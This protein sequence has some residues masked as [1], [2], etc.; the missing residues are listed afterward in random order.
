MN[1]MIEMLR[2]LPLNTEIQVAYGSVLGQT[3]VSTGTI[4]AKDDF[5]M[6]IMGQN[7]LPSLISY[8]TVDAFSI[9]GSPAAQ[10]KA[11]A[12]EEKAVPEAPAKVAPP[13]KKDLLC[14]KNIDV[15]PF[16]VS[17][18]ALK[19][20]FDV[21]CR[22][23][24]KLLQAA[25]DSFF[26]GVRNNNVDKRIQAAQN[27]LRTFQQQEDLGFA[28]SENACRLVAQLLSRTGRW[29]AELYAQGQMWEEAALSSFRSKD[30]TG[31]AVNAALALENPRIPNRREDMII[32][33]AHACAELDDAS[34]LEYLKKGEI[35]LPELVDDLILNKQGTPVKD[36]EA[37]WAL[38]QSLYPQRVIAGLLE[39]PATSQVL[40][41]SIS[42]VL[43]VNGTGTI[44]YLSDGEEL[45]VPF[46]NSQ[47]EDAVVM[48]KIT[49]P[50]AALSERGYMVRF[51]LE[52]GEAAHIC[53]AS[54]PLN[55]AHEA[56]GNDEYR[57]ACWICRNGLK[58]SND[59]ELW[60]LMVSAAADS[61]DT[62]LMQR[63]ADFCDENRARFPQ[64]CKGLSHFGQLHHALHNLEES[65]RLTE[66]AL[67][68]TDAPAKLRSGVLVQYMKYAMRLYNE[69]A[70]EKWLR[71][72]HDKA[73]EWLRI[74]SEE[75][76]H[77]PNCIKRHGQVLIWKIRSL[78]SLGHLDKAEEAYSQLARNYPN[79]PRL[80][81]TSELI[82]RTRQKLLEHK[83]T[84]AKAKP[85]F[86]LQ[87]EE[88]EQSVDYEVPNLDTTGKWED[89]NT[90]E[91]TFVRRVLEM[92][93]PHRLAP[94]L[95]AL[96]AGSMLNSN[97]TAL[98]HTMSAAVNNPLASPAY[99]AAALTQLLSHADFR[100]PQ[101]NRYASACVYL[102]MLF[103]NDNAPLWMRQCICLDEIPEFSGVL[104][105]LESFRH[106][107]GHAIDHYAAYR[108][109]IHNADG[110]HH[111]DL[112]SRAQ[113]LH[114]AY[115]AA[116]AKDSGTFNRFV[117]VKALAHNALRNYLDWVL[118]EDKDAL[119]DVRASFRDQFLTS[120]GRV[121]TE[122][123][124]KFIVSIWNSTAKDY[125]C[126]ES[127]SLQGS[128][129]NALRSSVGSIVDAVSNYYRHMD[130]QVHRRSAADMAHYEEIL[131]RLC[132]S[133]QEIGKACDVLTGVSSNREEQTGLFLLHYT[134]GELLAKLSGDWHL[135]Q[136]Q[137]LFCDFLRN[138][139][140]P[141]QDDFM[142]D[143]TGMLTG[144]FALMDRIFA[145]AAESG[146]DPQSHADRIFSRD[147]ETFRNFDTA[148]LLRR[149]CE[150]FGQSLRI[151]EADRY[152]NQAKLI[153]DLEFDELRQ[154]L[155]Q[156]GDTEGLDLLLWIYD[157][158]RRNLRFG[159][160]AE[161]MAI[162]RR[163]MSAQEGAD[164]A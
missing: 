78:L 70:S 31:T 85:A 128:R 90:T 24:K 149:Y 122:K 118:H 33:L 152:I 158:C 54:A 7:G 134:V 26:H 57:L 123:V 131:P 135:N 83:A 3:L 87:E 56:L 43:W 62:V 52:N 20:A 138:N 68:E 4:T 136:E 157:E 17:D 107:T 140:V 148:R 59:R 13:V 66:A 115:I 41:G 97:L 139:L 15:L 114:D 6:Q 132:E 35:H 69:S 133:L 49:T 42:K 36:E 163:R 46:R 14:R 48:E 156:A 162:L 119:R 77:E 151:P 110:R 67:E 106:H 50:G 12:V 146:L 58:T 65:L 92:D 71:K 112:I 79:D 93:G 124:D 142:P 160:L 55:L 76:P 137:Y 86:V 16:A 145:H 80:Q 37:N 9:L 81:A 34:A 29:H 89:L 143:F 126:A 21:L 44:T 75:L 127:A 51:V 40:L 121:S 141:L 73:E 82:C 45:T 63:V 111:A 109:D 5:Y 27:A 8:Q 38:L 30:F 23:E 100:Y 99:D 105:A 1:M 164:A 60:I 19:Q 84:L 159:Y 22:E 129:R 144:P 10:Q 47:V 64:T 147:H 102:R 91:E 95:T 96:H 39:T 161:C 53:Q 25:V 32:I 11:P 88:P 153:A 72:I 94:Q 150:I 61:N 103:Q 130:Q 155:R 108:D 2:Q 125:P 98:Y 28:W 101:L 120:D 154:A 18:H 74:F 116:P 117:H 113:H 104:D